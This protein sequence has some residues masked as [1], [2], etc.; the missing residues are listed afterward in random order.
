MVVAIFVD[1]SN[2]PPGYSTKQLKEDRREV[3]AALLGR[4]VVC[5]LARSL[6]AVDGRAL[7]KNS[8]RFRA[9]SQR[10]CLVCVW[11]ETLEKNI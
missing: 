3:A 7:A 5:S 10:V 11:N 9:N 2:T 1:P 8:L 4:F 6:L